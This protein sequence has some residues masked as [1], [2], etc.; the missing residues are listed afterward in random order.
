MPLN[1]AVQQMR[2]SLFSSEPISLSEEVWRV[3]TQQEEAETRTAI[4]NGK[5]YS[6]KFSG[7]LLVVAYSGLRC[8]IVLNIDDTLADSTEEPKLPV[9]GMWNDLSESFLKFISPFLESLEFPLVR[10][11]LGSVLVLE[12]A[13]KEDAY[14][15]LDKLLE[16][17]QIDPENMRELTYRVNW[18]AKSSVIKG[19]ELNRLTT[20]N[21]VNI[22]RTVM[23]MT[24]SEMTVAGA[25]KEIHTVRLELD[26]NTVLTHKTPFEKSVRLP[27][28]KELVALARENAEKG[29]CR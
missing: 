10:I 1:W 17:V 20:W 6:G 13:S 9:I 5:Q 15:Q 4:P 21:A 12:V 16:S 18:P 29:E 28:F 19:L 3:I 27:I 23:Q 22:S 25:G 24:G 8:D 2:V 7:G 14:R 11:A 26:H